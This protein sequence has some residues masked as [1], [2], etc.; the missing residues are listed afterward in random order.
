MSHQNRALL[1]RMVPDDG[2]FSRIHSN[3]RAMS[4]LAQQRRM[5][6][7]EEVT[8]SE[9]ERKVGCLTPF[10]RPASDFDDN[11]YFFCIARGG[12]Q[13]LE[14]DGSAEAELKATRYFR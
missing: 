6:K 10:V 2:L 11:W 3:A 7:E 9:L 5:V 1:L 14:T 8:L 12:G 4:R 13:A